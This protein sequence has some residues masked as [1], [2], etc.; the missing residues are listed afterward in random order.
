[1]QFVVVYIYLLGGF[2]DTYLASLA[3][4][5]GYHPP[6]GRVFRELRFNVQGGYYIWFP[7]CVGTIISTKRTGYLHKAT[8]RLKLLLHVGREPTIITT[9]YF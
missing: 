2:V 5:L 6:V 3:L 9:L 4:Y 8:A 7:P 1:M